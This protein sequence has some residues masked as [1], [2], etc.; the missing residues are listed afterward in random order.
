MILIILLIL[1]LLAILFGPMFFV[2]VVV[3]A[4]YLMS[5]GPG[6]PAEPGWR[7]IPTHFI[8][9]PLRHHFTPGLRAS[10]WPM[11]SRRAPLEPGKSEQNERH[12]Q[13]AKRV[14]G[15]NMR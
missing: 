13:C 10:A 15:V 2:V 11:T 6:H 7:C 5:A 3:G 4:L 1:I 8:A 14:P 12:D 9:A